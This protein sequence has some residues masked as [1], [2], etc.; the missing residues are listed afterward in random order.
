[1]S[2]AKETTTNKGAEI[3]PVVPEYRNSDLQAIASFEDALALIREQ[4]GDEGVVAAD[5]VIGNGFAILDNKDHLIGVPFAMVKWHFYE[6]KYDNSVAAVLLVTSDGRKYLMNDGS[7]GVCKQLREYSDETGRF[8][9][10]VARKGLT[11]SDYEYTDSEGKTTDAQT[12][13]IDLAAV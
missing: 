1:M 12:Y 7:T 6:G 5:Q 4:F 9:G 3:T 2:N 13:Y 11:R 10:L 8:G